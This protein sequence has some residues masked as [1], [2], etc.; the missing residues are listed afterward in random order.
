MFLH[1]SS[2]WG[3]GVDGLFWI[4]LS[5]EKKFH[6]LLLNNNKKQL[7]LHLNHTLQRLKQLKE[8]YTS[9]KQRLRHHYH[10]ENLLHQQPIQHEEK[11]EEGIFKFATLI[12]TLIKPYALYKQWELVL[13]LMS[14]TFGLS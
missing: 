6:Y 10:H 5:F 1:S 8:L 2:T 14:L 3:L 13:V 7:K 9:Q 4:W 11:K 12:L